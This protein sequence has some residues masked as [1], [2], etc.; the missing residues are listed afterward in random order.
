M[1]QEEDDER[2]AMGIQVDLNVNTILSGTLGVD[3]SQ[4]G[5]VSVK[6]LTREGKAS[7]TTWTI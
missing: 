3:F 5:A 4:A 6:Q 1:M 2:T 7:L